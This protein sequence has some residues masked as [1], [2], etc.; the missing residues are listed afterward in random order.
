MRLRLRV[1]CGLAA[2]ALLLAG[3]GGDPSSLPRADAH[4]PQPASG[5]AAPATSPPPAASPS[6]ATSPPAAAAV[7]TAPPLR[8]GERFLEIR[9]PR[10][11]TPA[12]PTQGTDEYRCFLMDPKLTKDTLITGTDFLPA[13]PRLVHHV[14]LYRVDPDEVARARQLDAGEPGD[15]WTCFGSSGIEGPIGQQLDRAPWLG[16][17]APGGTESVL[18][19]GIGMPVSKGTQIVMQIHYNLVNG[20]G[21]DRSAVKLRLATDNGKYK[22]LR[23][24]LMPAPVEL[25]CRPGAHGGLCYRDM[26]LSETKAR[27]GVAG[28][29]GDLLHL[30]CGPI[31]PGPTQSCTRQVRAPMVVRAAAGHMHLLGR[32]ITVVADKGSTSEKAILDIPNWDFDNQG[33]I[34]LAKPITLSAGDSLTVT[35]THDQGLRDVLPAFRGKPERY[36]LWGEGTTDEMCLGIVFYTD[37]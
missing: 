5:S 11:Y 21:P 2:L 33:S 24:M 14:I 6:A 8:A 16:A 19:D 25:P 1:T 32:A 4:L 36:V 15:G 12:V 28:A 30:L 9:M 13:D 18:G 22:A 37:N 29:T 10:T 7:S 3:C 34:P 26:S 35:C 17:W 20:T 23:T 27:F 31:A